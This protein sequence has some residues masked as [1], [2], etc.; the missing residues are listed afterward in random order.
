ML[1]ERPGELVTRDELRQRLW[2]DGTTVDFDHGLSTTINKIRDRLGDSAENPRFIETI[3]RRGYRFRGAS[4]G[5]HAGGGCLQ[6][7]QQSA[8][9]C[10][11]RLPVEISCG[12]SP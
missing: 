8:N 1:I 12:A 7:T 3:A 11:S 10:S 9:S 2:G 5:T 4:S 6:N